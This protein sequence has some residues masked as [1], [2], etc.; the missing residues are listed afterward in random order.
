MRDLVELGVSGLDLATVVFGP[1]KL[2]G[3]FN[4]KD[5]V[6]VKDYVGDVLTGV[7]FIP[8]FVAEPPIL[9]ERGLLGAFGNEGCDYAGFHARSPTAHQ[10]SFRTVEVFDGV[11]TKFGYSPQAAANRTLDVEIYL[12]VAVASVGDPSVFHRPSFR[13]ELEVKL[14][15]TAPRNCAE[16]VAGAFSFL[17]RVVVRRVRIVERVQ[18]EIC[19]GVIP[20]RGTVFVAYLMRFVVYGE[21]RPVACRVGIRFLVRASFNV[22]FHAATA[23]RVFERSPVHPFSGCQGVVGVGVRYVAF[24]VV[25]VFLCAGEGV[26]HFQGLSVRRRLRLAV[27]GV[28]ISVSVQPPRAQLICARL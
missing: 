15:V 20:C 26:F 1:F 16:I 12:G 6:A 8:R 3:A 18:V 19:P 27:V 25:E 4:C 5:V 14:V 11:G 21:A 24:F 9:L 17:R 7:I 23:G 10:V 2:A 28:K 22:V 13:E